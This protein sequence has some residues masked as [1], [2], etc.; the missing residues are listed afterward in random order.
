M[1]RDESGVYTRPANTFTAPSANVDISSTDAEEY[2][3]D[4][5]TALTE[6]VVRVTST[7]AGRLAR[8]TGTAGQQG[9]TTGL[10]ED[11]SGNVGIGT[12]TPSYKLHIE[13]SAQ[14]QPQLL[15]RATYNGVDA[16]YFNFEHGRSGAA[17]QVNDALGS[18]VWRG[19]STNLAFNNAANLMCIV[20]NVGA[21]TVDGLLHA[22]VNSGGGIGG[23]WQ[24]SNTIF[25]IN[26]PL[27]LPS[28]T[29]GTL[30][31]AGTVGAGSIAYVT[32]A[33]ATTQ[34]SIVAGGG[35]NKVLVFSD[36]T[37]W[38]IT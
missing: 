27:K 29:V 6:S 37:N 35:S 22:Y 32:D 19:R 2:F 33:N 23:S 4:L 8:F 34:N 17:S 36:G 24:L 13:S 18:F 11:G 21:T 25:E 38:R 12:S 30:P 9:Q 7:T 31:A 28:Y 10:F 3:D 14:Y 1:P 5:D 15:L 26:R 16:G 20:S